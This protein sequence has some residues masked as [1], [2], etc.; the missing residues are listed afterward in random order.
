MVEWSEDG[1]KIVPCVFTDAQVANRVR[2]YT[3]HLRKGIKW[4]EGHPFTTENILFYREDVQFNTDSPNVAGF[5]YR[6]GDEYA[7]LKVLSEHT[8]QITFKAPHLLFHTMTVNHLGF[9]S[10]PKHYLKQLHPKYT[11]ID[12]REKKAKKAGFDTGLQL[13]PTKSSNSAPSWFVGNLDRST[14]FAYKVI[15]AT[16]QRLVRT[17][18]P[19]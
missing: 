10:H 13:W 5:Q 3:Y 9:T 18:N 11:P 16:P 17:R 19:Y 14:L 6:S 15:Q 12:E 2:V 8:F 7:K 1:S 4:S